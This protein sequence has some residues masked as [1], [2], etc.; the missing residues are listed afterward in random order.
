MPSRERVEDFLKA[1]VHGSHV[2]A[3]ANFYHDDATM[4]ENLGA[5]RRGIETLMAREQA[6]L[7]RIERMHTHPVRTFLVDGD[8]VA[9]RWTFDMIDKT[10]T[11]RRLEELALQRWRGDRIAEEQFFYDTATAW[12]VVEPD[13]AAVQ[14]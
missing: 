3:I 13:D 2:Q 8:H 4:Q 14:N 12:L 10:G 5:P 1:V 11:V 9:I 6:T 7:D